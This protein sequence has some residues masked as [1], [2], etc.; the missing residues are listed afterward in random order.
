MKGTWRP[1]VS[2][3][4]RLVDNIEVD[5]KQWLLVFEVWYFLH[6]IRYSHNIAWYVM[7]ISKVN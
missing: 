7:L 1:S 5:I 2:K 4:K 3:T 6:H